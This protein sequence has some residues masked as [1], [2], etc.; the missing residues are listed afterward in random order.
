M[1]R[2]EL[3]F[4]VWPRS[5]DTTNRLLTTLRILRKHLG[6]TL[7]AEVWGFGNE[8]MAM[9]DVKQQIEQLGGITFHA[10]A[11]Q[12]VDGLWKQFQIVSPLTSRRAEIGRASCRERVS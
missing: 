4:A 5:K 2:A 8:I 7:P 12:P 1:P 11:Q 10:V 6:C 3:T 9:G